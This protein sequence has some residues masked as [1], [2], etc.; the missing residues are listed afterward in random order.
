MRQR[1][2]SGFVAAVLMVALAS[3]HSSSSS[4]P[5]PTASLAGSRSAQ[6]VFRPIKQRF[7]SAGRAERA[8]LD[9]NLAWFAANY[10]KDGLAPLAQVY[11]AVI[12]V[13]RD[14]VEGAERLI[15]GAGVGPSGTA[16][17][18]AELVR[19]AVL[20][21]RQAPAAAVER[22]VPLIGKLIDGF[23][24]M[25][26]DEY[27]VSAALG[28]KRWY[29]AVAYMD[30]WLRDA[31][32]DDASVVRKE[33][34]R[35][36]EGVP[37]E[38]L[39]LMLH[40]M[41]RDKARTGYGPD[42][43]KAVVARLAVVAIEAQDTG[44]A[45]RLVESTTGSP[46][47]G[48]AIEGLEELASSGGAA[49]VDGRT[50]GLLISTGQ[51]GLGARAADVLAGVVDTL[52]T[53]G[54]G[55]AADHVRLTT[56][57]ERDPKRTDLAL[58]S[59]ASQGASIVIAGLD[60]TQAKAAASFAARTRVPVILLSELGDDTAPARPA[61][62]LG[63]DGRPVFDA[64]MASLALH[65]ARSVAPVGDSPALA[66]AKAAQLRE[67]KLS[68]FQ[69]T[70]CD[71][72]PSGIGTSRFP[73]EAWRAARVDH[74]LFLGD[75]AC[76]TEALE[77]A[78]AKGGLSVRTATA[79]LASELAAEPARTPALFA[80]AGLF[81]LRRG[82]ATSPLTG[83]QK[84]QGKAPSWYAALGHD[85]AALARSALRSLPADKVTDAREVE[86]RHEAAAAALSRAEAR[87]FTTDARGFSGGNV[88]DRKINVVE[89]R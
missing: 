45:R 71:S 83:F 65:G 89:V 15:E 57:D 43:R 39:E 84:R 47:L 4:E 9:P 28:A 1:Q 51:S 13:D 63:Q 53:A 24:R 25:L 88:I 19:G 34:R 26:L 40:A 23:A 52:Q 35:M 66:A 12:A 17:D 69:V 21:K 50:I 30:L 67:G 44:L 31:Q 58:Q 73:V 68:F 86:H 33:V 42:I 2:L 10:P 18:L 87:L 36:L 37:S 70:S 78:V 62:S 46:S 80:S 59:L 3:C 22:F 74:L 29:E 76:A 49:T 11:R 7:V 72:Q 6:E 82:E 20:L 85:A 32:D 14:D 5:V 64:L 56:R 61:F 38:V 8:S 54:E 79:L 48:D 16:H 77:G 81:P 60:P 27:V 55:G 41:Q 75:A